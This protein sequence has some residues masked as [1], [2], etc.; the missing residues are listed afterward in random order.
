MAE[1]FE[2]H[3]PADPYAAPPASE[4]GSPYSRYKENEPKPS[5]KVWSPA[6]IWKPLEAPDYL[7]HG[8]FVRGSLGLIVAYGASLKTWLLEDLALSVAMG[9]PWLERFPTKQGKAIIIDFESG[10]YELRRRAHRIAKGRGFTIPVEGFAFASMP[11]M[12]LAEDSFFDALRPLATEYRFIGIDSLAAG[13]GGIDENDSRFATSLN[14]L[15]AIA[16][17]AGSLIEVLHHSRKGGGEDTDQRELVRGTSAIFN[18]C[19]VVLQL[20]RAKDDGAFAVHQTK[21]RGGKAV[22]PFVVR[23]DDVGTDASVVIARNMPETGGDEIMGT[24]KA[25]GNA[26]RAILLLLAGETG[27]T[28]KAQVYN[29]IAGAKQAKLKALAELIEAKTI[30]EHEGTWRLSSEVTQ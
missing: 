9:A 25:I 24:S 30:V 2:T 1:D 7:V 19:D 4:N 22:E 8:L 5:F 13:S 21:A 15:K 18:A 6:E 26:K 20:A 28:S 14:K 27:L 29:R 10:S 12:S 11:E 17:P 16:E 23:V 3:P